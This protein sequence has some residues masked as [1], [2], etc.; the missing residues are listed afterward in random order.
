MTHNAVS[1]KQDVS[2]DT[3]RG[4]LRRADNLDNALFSVGIEILPYE[5]VGVIT[6][7]DGSIRALR[8]WPLPDMGVEIVVEHVTE[9]VSYLVD[10]SLGLTVPNPRICVGVQIGGP[11]DPATG[12]V[13]RYTN[14]PDDY[15][16]R[17]PPYEW[18]DVPLV[19]L[20]QAATGCVTVL[21]NDA[22]AYA[23]Y[24]QKLGWGQRTDSFA[25]ILIRDGV[26]GAVVLDN[27]LLPIPFEIGHIP[28]SPSGRRCD[29]GKRG[30]LESQ[31]G[32]RAIRAMV[33][34]LINSENVDRFEIA[35]E[36]ANRN[37]ERGRAALQVFQRAGRSIA[38]GIA[39]V[40]ALFG[41]RH[42]VIYAPDALTGSG[43]GGAAADA[44][45]T[46]VGR[47]RD[48]T[49]CVFERCE[50]VIESLSSSQRGAQGAAL[51]ALNRHFFVSLGSHRWEHG[52]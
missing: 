45:M 27:H 14:P 23:V 47:F 3:V 37:D 34:E 18:K 21:E 51:A 5:L 24:E 28:I 32:R 33:A 4:I 31:A 40:L 36:V 48:H 26:G 30:C 41:P 16:D 49:F 35:I 1:N 20:V 50:V 46:E 8:R 7:S 25:L 11:V 9:L 43:G 6:E 52:Q 15:G 19:D 42:V 13:R 22:A 29:C 2:A 17:R 39:T 38:Q 10:S 12:I 44:F